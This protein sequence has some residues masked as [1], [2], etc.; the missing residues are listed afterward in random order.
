MCSSDL[1]RSSSHLA[2]QSISASYLSPSY[3]HTSARR[4]RQLEV[5]GVREGPSRRKAQS[6]LS[7]TLAASP[8]GI[9]TH[10]RHVDASAPCDDSGGGKSRSP[11]PSRS[12]SS[13]MNSPR[14]AS[15][16][17]SPIRRGRGGSGSGRP[18][19]ARLA[20]RAADEEGWAGR[21]LGQG[22]SGTRWSSGRSSN[23]GSG[24]P[25]SPVRG[26]TFPFVP[27]HI[28][29]PSLLVPPCSFPPLP[30]PC[31]SCHLLPFILDVD[32]DVC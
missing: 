5:A 8:I 25:Y 32:V 6:A 22:G 12:S 10:T 19:Y 17:A 18:A 13:S 9:T 23:S 27:S 26:T 7:K 3:S 30:F 21:R 4:Q 20:P 2:S 14:S 28:P 31:S 11:R 15:L 29:L 1:R 16:R 24:A